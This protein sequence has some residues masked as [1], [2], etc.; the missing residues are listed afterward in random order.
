MDVP[1]VDAIL[2]LIETRRV[3]TLFLPPTLIYVVLAHPRLAET[4]TSSLTYLISAAAPIA[5]EKLVE[6]VERLGPVGKVL[7]R[8]LRAPYWTGRERQVG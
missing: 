1:E 2:E 6:G 4:D 3:T 7:K 5:P 8:E